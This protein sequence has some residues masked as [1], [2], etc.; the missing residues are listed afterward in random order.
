M[1][2]QAVMQPPTQ[3][4]PDNLNFAWDRCETADSLRDKLADVNSPTW[5]NTAA[6]LMREART[7][8]VWEFLTLR[9]IQHNF[10]RI[11]PLL[12]RQRPVWEHLLR[13]AH[14]LGRL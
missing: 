4:P 11:S 2:K 6:W 5:H 3:L 8:Q 1:Y 14:E 13:T 9:Q 10:T 12:G 7:E